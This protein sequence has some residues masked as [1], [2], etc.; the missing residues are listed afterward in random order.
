MV[1]YWSYVATPLF[2]S[3]IGFGIIALFS[4]SDIQLLDS[5]DFL[6]VPASMESSTSGDTKAAQQAAAD[7]AARSSSGIERA[8]AAAAVAKARQPPPPSAPPAGRQ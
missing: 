4:A 3:V 8:A 7:K 5:Q 2:F 6:I 1:K